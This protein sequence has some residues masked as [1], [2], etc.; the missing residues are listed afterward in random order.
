MIFLHEDSERRF[1]E[2]TVDVPAEDEAQMLAHQLADQKGR[3][4]ESE[5]RGPSRM[6]VATH[7]TIKF[8]SVVIRLWCGSLR[9]TR[10]WWPCSLPR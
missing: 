2:Q 10:R 3:M 5:E 7:D 6:L 8:L 1:V 9:S 4:D